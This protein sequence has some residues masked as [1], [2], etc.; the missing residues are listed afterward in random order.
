MRFLVFAILAVCMAIPA[1]HA[2][3]DTIY[4]CGQALSAEKDNFQTD[5]GEKANFCD[6]YTRQLAY[7]EEKRKFREKLIERQKNFVEPRT[8][9]WAQY[10]KNLDTRWKTNNSAY[11]ERMKRVASEPAGPPTPVSAKNQ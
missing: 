3:T 2:E 1:A 10:E 9:A 7:A 11:Q 6:I 4:A 5:P 8:Q